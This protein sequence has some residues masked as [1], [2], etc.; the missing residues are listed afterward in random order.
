MS[1]FKD[2]LNESSL[3]R[4]YRHMQEHDSGTITA[5][6]DRR[7]CGNG[8]KYTKGENKARN[9]V[10][11]SSLLKRR[12]SVTKVKGTYIEN[13]GSANE[14]PVGENVFLV[15][16]IND[17]GNLKNTLK[18]LGE[19]YEQDSILFIPKGG[20]EGYLIGTNKCEDG[21]PGYGKT[22]KLNNAIFG[23]SGEFFTRVNGRPFI[24]KENF[25]DVPLPNSNMGRLAVT[26]L[27]K[28]G[29]E[30]YYQENKELYEKEN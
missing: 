23:K 15:V 16:D 22:I 8:E 19:E 13:Y 30:F 17:T 28:K 18:L 21:Y 6:R 1:N 25:K 2:Y 20:Q 12:Y 4:V 9:K 14:T 11:L 24:L 5:F 10:L 29:W 26:I 27:D 7:D 3:S